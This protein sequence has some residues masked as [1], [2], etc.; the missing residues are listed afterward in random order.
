MRKNHAI[1]EISCAFFHTQTQSNKTILTSV[2]II[3]LSRKPS[4]L[5]VSLISRQR[6]CCS[7]VWT[8]N[9][10]CF[11]DKEHIFLLGTGERPFIWSVFL[12]RKRNPHPLTLNLL[13]YKACANICYIYFYS[14]CFF[15]QWGSASS[16]LKSA[17][18]VLLH[19]TT[20]KP[21]VFFVGTKE[22]TLYCV[23]FCWTTE[24]TCN[25]LR[26]ESRRELFRV[27]R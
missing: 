11:G 16:C 19:R 10:F 14:T 5:C 4:R 6:L 1:D 9:L 7:F 18:I 15:L 25:G 17:T 27:G 24:K 12:F 20:Q 2:Y 23:V 21:C 3:F 26:V 8:I 13:G 22:T